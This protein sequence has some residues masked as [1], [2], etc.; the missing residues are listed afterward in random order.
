[1]TDDDMTG[2]RAFQPTLRAR[3]LALLRGFEPAK[4]HP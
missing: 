2:E 1:M 4:V 3:S